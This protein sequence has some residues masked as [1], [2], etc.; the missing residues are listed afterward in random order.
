MGKVGNAQTNVTLAGAKMEYYP[1]LC[2]LVKIQQIGML[3][4]ETDPV[5]MGIR[6]C[7]MGKGENAQISVTLA[8]AIMDNYQEQ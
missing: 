8:G 6:H 7:K 3:E 1:V 4:L 2:C 5:L